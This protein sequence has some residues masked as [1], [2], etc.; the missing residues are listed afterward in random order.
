MFSFFRQTF[1]QWARSGTRLG[2]QRGPVR[3]LRCEALE[4][5]TLLSL[6][7][8]EFL[9]NTSRL[10]P[11]NQPAVASSSIGRSVVVWTEAKA[12]R[13]YDIKAQRYDSSGRK[14][15]REIVI[16][17]SREHEH[18][19]TVAMDARGNFVV[20]W[21][22]DFTP[23]DK[24]I[25][26][27]R[28]RSD[29]TRIGS[30]F[31]VA[32]SHRSEHAPSVAM[33]ANGDFVV[34]YSFQFTTSDADVYAKLYRAN[35]SLARTITVADSARSE[36]Q[37]SVAAASDGRFAIA[38]VRQDNVYLQR[39]T[40]TGTRVGG[41][42]AVAA[43]SRR[44]QAPDVAMDNSGNAVVAF[45][46]STSTWN[47][48]A[49][50]VSSSGTLGPLVTVATTSA[51]EAAP[52]VAIHPT[53]KKFVVAYQSDTGSTKSVKVTEVSASNRVVRTSVLGT[54]LT[55]PSV[56]VGTSSRFLVVASSIGR[57]GID[58]DGGVFGRMGVL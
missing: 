14:V 29:G 10:K 3:Q 35:G 2:A 41:E 15:G 39:Y 33:A 56:S 57:R 9:V 24:D 32:W 54:R 45:Q 22:I 16:T 46:T 6:T 21:T 51:Q 49:R 58:A 1:R 8:T 12:S 20:V 43:T 27:A 5:R 34:S 48:Q 13:D 42:V 11:Q 23:T 47:V 44:E 25:W 17:N 36:G 52:S 50:R 7:G 37:S 18:S 31:R 40:R 55:D 28:Y 53:T 19:P 26:A 30:A 38:H 4:D